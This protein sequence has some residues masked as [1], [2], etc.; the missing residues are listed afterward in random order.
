METPHSCYWRTI[1]RDE[2]EL[3]GKLA[4]LLSSL[5]EVVDV[6]M[7]CRPASKQAFQMPVI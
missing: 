3:A 7:D 5:S 1:P 2:R 6:K 4:K